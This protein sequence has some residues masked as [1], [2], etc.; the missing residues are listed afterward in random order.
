[1]TLIL[2]SLKSFS[3][4]TN[5]VLSKEQSTE[6]YKGLIQVE[7]M[8]NYI[9]ELNL[10]ISEME[11]INSNSEDI[12]SNLKLQIFQLENLIKDKE[13]FISNQDKINKIEKAKLLEKNK[14]KFGF[15][16]ISGLGYGTSN[17]QPQGF[18]GIGISYNLFRF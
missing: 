5:L 8:K 16:V 10:I 6:I 3:Q 17:F 11:F 9:E 4:N 14:K 12:I 2:I 15:S 13:L 1:M 18:I 7:N